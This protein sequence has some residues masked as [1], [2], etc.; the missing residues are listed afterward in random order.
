[1]LYES[2][3]IGNPAHIRAP[4]KSGPGFAELFALT[5]TDISFLNLAAGNAMN[6]PMLA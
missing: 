2:S 5:Y 1:M 4:I 3:I 6:T